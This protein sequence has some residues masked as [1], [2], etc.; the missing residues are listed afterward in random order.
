MPHRH[1]QEPRS[2]SAEDG[3]AIEGT[4]RRDSTPTAPVP[5]VMGDLAHRV[6]SRGP[7]ACESDFA[8]F[9]VFARGFR[10]IQ[11]FRRDAGDEVEFITVHVVR[12]A[13]R[14]PCLRRRGLRSLGGATCGPPAART[15]DPRSQHYEVREQRIR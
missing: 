4:P 9:V 7:A 5:I 14:R 12:L 1:P 13:R 15:F 11:V 2:A 3:W 6:A 8:R 10:E